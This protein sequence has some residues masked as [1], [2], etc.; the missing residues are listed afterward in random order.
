MSRSPSNLLV[1]H[2]HIDTLAARPWEYLS[3]GICLIFMVGIIA[4]IAYSCLKSSRVFQHTFQEATSYAP[5]LKKQSRTWFAGRLCRFMG[6]K[7]ERKNENE[8]ESGYQGGQGWAEEI[9]VSEQREGITLGRVLEN[10]QMGV[11]RCEASGWMECG[12]HEEKPGFGGSRQRSVSSPMKMKIK[13]GSDLQ[14]V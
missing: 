10:K 13:L 6:R 14:V 11:K 8:K 4:L 5:Q 9:G 3:L 2:P 1:S 7:V 12:G